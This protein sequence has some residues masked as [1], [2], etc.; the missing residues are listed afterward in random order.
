[1]E[2]FKDDKAMPVLLG[3]GTPAVELN[4]QLDV[5]DGIVFSA[6]LDRLAD[7]ADNL[8]VMDQKTTG[9]TVSARYFEQY[10]PDTQ[11]SLYTYMGKAAF[12]IPVKGVIIDAAQIA[13][14]FTRF[15][16]GMTFRTDDQLHEW[17]DGAMHTIEAARRATQENYFP[18]NT[19]ACGNYG[20]CPF[21]PVCGR[22]PGA[23]R[24]FLAA[25]FIL[26]GGYDPLEQR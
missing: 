22:D 23:R 17:Y 1:L 11:M 21:R 14:G 15:E 16:R 2:Q 19:A 12:G 4:V 6:H 9:S 5:D 10:S 13:V 3:N 26:G 7:Y 20:G 25:D 8:Y 24:N 18:M